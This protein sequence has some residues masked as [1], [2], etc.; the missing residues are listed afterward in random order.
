MK[1]MT[2]LAKIIYK[3]TYARQMN[4]G[5]LENWEDTI[6]RVIEG[7]VGKFRGTKFLEQGEEDKLKKYMRELKAMP[8]GRGLWFSG[9]EAQKDIGGLGLNN[10]AFFS[11]DHVEKLVIT[12]D[13]LMLGAGVG[14]SVEHKY[15]SLIPKVK[16]S[17]EITHKKTN[18]ADFI[19]PDSREGWCELTRKIMDSYF[20]TG[21]GFSY[22]TVCLR[23]AG[24]PIKK[25]G[26]KASGALP[27]IDFVE[28]VCGILDERAGKHVRPIDIVDIVCAIGEMVVSGNVRRSAIIILGDC[29]DKEYLKAKRWD[30]GVIPSQ[31]SKANFSVV[32]DDIDDVHPLFWETYLN[33]EPFGIV[34][35]K[36]MRIYG[37][38]GNKQKDNCEGVNPC[39]EIPLADG[40]VCNLQEIF[41]PNVESEDEFKEIARLMHR[42]GKRVST[43]NYHNEITDSI[44]KKNRRIGTGITGCLQSPLFNPA[45][46]DNVYKELEDENIK[47]S[48]L[49][50]INPSVRLTTVKPSGT[51]SILGNVTA[52]IHPAFS[53][54]YI[55][56][57]RF[58]YND[59]L[60]PVLR[61]AGHT[62]EPERKMD[63][64]I[65]YNTVVVDFYC[66]TPEG[67][68]CADEDFDTI[69]Q[70]EV[71][72]MA[73]KHW[74]DNSVSVTVYYK[75]D[76]IFKIKE[77]LK[78]NL[79]ELKTI[80]FLCHNEHG[81]DQAPIEAISK[82]EYEKYTAK[83]K[84]VNFEDI[85]IGEIESME[86]E[87]GV[88]P[89]K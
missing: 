24:E 8:A 44:V 56:R 59:A 35:L 3:R 2:T 87:N 64:T 82:E 50:G 26:G 57:V 72:K 74:S 49:L 84:P 28:K 4:N 40:E 13:Y 71:L 21:K 77:W 11:I 42:W 20:L 78:D 15:V 85:V 19:V 33:G 9:T 7:N 18:D 67:T 41:L 37:R 23:D 17:V 63:G 53:R 88:C 69:K 5:K 22:S 52:G 54:Y 66:E 60:V 6:N 25:F 47:Y 46:L 62:I 30:L 43:E 31:R 1:E 86:C 39:G 70:L 55:R 81:F 36:N 38:M 75:K 48:K 58:A 65:D 27:L 12:Q 45:T 79:K 34:N 80:S 10:C 68:P 14:V 51:L 73:Q 32:C 89:V 61:K 83:L 76:E 29:W 16:S